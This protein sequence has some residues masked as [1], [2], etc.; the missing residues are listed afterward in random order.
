MCAFLKYNFDVPDSKKIRLIINTDAKNEADDQYA[1]V[2]AL[3]TPKF[4]IKGIIAA[5]F[6]TRRTQQSMQESYE[7]VLKVLLLMDMQEKVDVYRGA[8]KAL[9]DEFTPEMSEGA[10]LIVREAM[11]QDRFMLFFLAP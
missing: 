11:I 1:I 3:L 5:H 2:H 6:G 9:K 8:T 7:E 4:C 10:E